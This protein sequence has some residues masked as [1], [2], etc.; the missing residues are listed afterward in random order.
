MNPVLL[1]MYEGL[2]LLSVSPHKRRTV[3][4]T[5]FRGTIL[6]LMIANLILNCTWEYFIV[7]RVLSKVN[8]EI[9][10][11]KSSQH[12]S[13]DSA[14]DALKTELVEPFPVDAEVA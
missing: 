2:I 10:G 14:G 7:N 11:M 5:S 4:P 9:A 6:G 13:R 12:A 1:W 8:A 3:M